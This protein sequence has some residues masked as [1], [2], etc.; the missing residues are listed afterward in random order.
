M[1]VQSHFLNAFDM[2]PLYFCS[3]SHFQCVLRVLIPPKN[4]NN[5]KLLW[6]VLCSVM[7]TGYVLLGVL[8]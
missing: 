2:L 3:M 1:F 4:L 6:R 5:E 8:L 7:G